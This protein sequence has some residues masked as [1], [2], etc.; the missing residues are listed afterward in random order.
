MNGLCTDAQGCVVTMQNYLESHLFAT[1]PA[2]PRHL[3]RII[4]IDSTP[5]KI[6]SRPLAA[7]PRFPAQ[8]EIVVRF[9]V[10]TQKTIVE[11]EAFHAN[12]VTGGVF[13]TIHVC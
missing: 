12:L 6:E 4:L 8:S 5:D 7:A 9:R 3:A 13:V 1:F 10:P 11:N 2:E